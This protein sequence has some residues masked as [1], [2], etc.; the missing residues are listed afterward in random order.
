MKVSYSWNQAAIAKN[1]TTTA[2]LIITFQET[3][4]NSANRLPLNLSLVLDRSGS[5][6]GYPLTNAKNAAK[7]LV[8]YLTPEDHVSVVVYDDRAETIVEPQLVTD[9]KTIQKQ[10]SSIRA[11]GLTNLSGGWLMGCDLVKNNQSTDKLNRVLLLT[12]GQANRGI[13]EPKT[14]IKAAKDKAAAGIITT[15]IGFGTYFNEDLLISI[16][17]AAEGN[18]YFIQSPE[19]AVQVFDIEMESLV[20]V[21]AQNLTVTLQLEEQIAVSEILNDYSTKDGKNEIEIFIGDVYGVE[22][23]PLALQFELPAFSSVGKQKIATVS[24]SYE[25]IVDDTIT[26]ITDTLPLTI[27]VDTTEKIEQIEPD[28]E[29]TQQASQLR[30]AKKKDEAINFADKGNYQQAA[31]ILRE[32]IA[33]LKLKALNE[34][35]E[36]AEEIEQLDYYAQSLEKKRFDLAT[37]KEMRDQSYQAKNRTRD[38]L[39]LRGTTGDAA[40]SL[41][42]VYDAESGIVLKCDRIKGKLR[43]RVVS[44]GY[45]P[46]F[47]VQFPRNIR[48]EG[49]S[50]VVDNVEPS[51]N[52]T[53]Y[54]VSGDIR[55]LLK[56]GETLP[57]ITSSSRN[58][59]KAKVKG[60]AADLETT[61][62]VG[63]GVLVQCIKEKSKLRA[64]VVS[65][66]FNPDWN[67]RFPRSIR[68][69]G[70]MYVVDEVKESSQGGFYLA[71]GTI[72]KFVQS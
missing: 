20:S 16:A 44:E 45:N 30:I 67:M 23:K 38:D 6:S 64:R 13:Y 4:S 42:V 57:S 63:D 14:L 51:A 34:Y 70:M 28:A 8:E 62:K 53:F 33:K 21:V 43:I 31:K 58:F 12:D 11:G 69:E 26:K 47:N 15:T 19:D 25:T 10:I 27:T 1:Q 24:Y 66:G 7:K 35:F 61:D 49:A 72:K 52:G 5:M 46:D 56:P 59:Q 36:I 17:D 29:I 37:R 68:E 32:A 71:Y 40:N 50:Y 41:P 3:D 65:D 18:F 22:G 48:Q 54:R 9:R 39:K 2:D 55:R 60:T